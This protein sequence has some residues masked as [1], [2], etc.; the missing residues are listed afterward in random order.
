MT[1]E[2]SAPIL[3][4]IRIELQSQNLPR[5][6]M[7]IEVSH[8]RRWGVV[9]SAVYAL[10]V[11]GVLVPGAVLISGGSD[12][13]LSWGRFLSDLRSSYM[14][15]LLWIPIMMVLAGQVLLLF[16]SVDTSWRRLKPQRNIAVACGMA[17]GLTAL[18]ASSAIWSVGFAIGGND[19][20]KPL[21]DTE[22]RTLEF[23]MVLWLL[24]G[25]VFYIYLRNSS[26]ATTRIV[27]WLLRGSILELLIVVPCHIVVRR[28][29]DC[30]APIFTSFGIA[31]GIA[32]M[33]LSFGPS[34]LLLYKRQLD[35]YRR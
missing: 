24:W 8:M 11:V 29:H 16:L 33:L 13:T 27:S 19:I 9:V 4:P 34:V 7:S 2:N 17:G 6:F 1:P 23:V 15:W 21:F 35:A 30:C 10:V 26:E 5:A 18:L 3:W 20:W 31:T 32:V 14:A 28:R 12:S 25:V 22:A